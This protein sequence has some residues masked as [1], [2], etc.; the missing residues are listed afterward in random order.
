MFAFCA[1]VL[2]FPGVSSILFPRSEY[3]F[4]F[5]YFVDYLRNAFLQFLKEN[6]ESIIFNNLPVTICYRKIEKKIWWMRRVFCYYFKFTH[7]P[8][9]FF[10]IFY[11]S[12]LSFALF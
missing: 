2:L 7:S 5:F 3:P 4:F 10:E 1:L 12:L 9:F 6:S 11:Y 8:R